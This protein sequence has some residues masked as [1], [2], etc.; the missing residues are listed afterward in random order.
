VGLADAVQKLGT[1]AQAPLSFDGIRDAL[2]TY[3]PDAL[4]I[5]MGA[6]D[7]YKVAEQ[8]VQ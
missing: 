4:I 2:E 7:I 1:L 5:T 3:G 8:L 6:G